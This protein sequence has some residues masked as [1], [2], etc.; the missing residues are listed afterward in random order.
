LEGGSRSF[1]LLW[2]LIFLSTFSASLV[3]PVI[4]YLVNELM[5]EEAAAVMMIGLLNA[6]YNSA[7]TLTS[8]PGGIFADK[9]GRKP[10]ITASLLILPFSFLL[11]YL[12]NNCYYMIAGE[13]ISGISMGFLVPAAS[14]MIVDIVPRASLSMAYEIFNLSWILGE[15][16]SPILGGL[17]SD[18]VDIHFPFLVALMLSLP[19]ITASLKL[20]E[21]IKV[22]KLSG[23][24][25]RK[26]EAGLSSVYRRVLAPFCGVEA[27]NGL[28]N[29]I[30][31]TLLVVYP[32]YVLKVSALGMGAI[33]SIGWGD[34]DSSLPDSWRK[35][36]G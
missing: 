10:L 19:C 33:L 35:A 22:S 18:A 36:R 5:V 9:L 16:P 31:L 4:P 28:G 24:F 30:L 27:L 21:R 32:L 13:V 17:L 34:R 12:S 15:I 29:G 11:Y 25:T 3:S 7:K 2:M 1:L 20:G 14:A 26:D 23:D 6:S 8:I